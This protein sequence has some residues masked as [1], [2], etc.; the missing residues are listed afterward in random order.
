MAHRLN[1]R[2][3]TLRTESCQ[4]AAAAAAQRI[5]HWAGLLAMVA[6]VVA[7]VVALRFARAAWA[8]LGAGVVALG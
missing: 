5:R 6:P 1:F 7:V 4:A 3:V 2:G 8:A